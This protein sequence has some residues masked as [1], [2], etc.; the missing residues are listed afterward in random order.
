[1]FETTY[2]WPSSEEA[3]LLA[4]RSEVTV[5][6]LLPRRR[7]SRQKHLQQDNTKAYTT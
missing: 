1:M 7:S 5:G 6:G 2:A 4:R 3:E